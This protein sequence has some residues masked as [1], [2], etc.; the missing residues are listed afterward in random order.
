MDATFLQKL[1]GLFV[2]NPG[3]VFSII[4]AIGAAIW[5]AWWLR[6]FIGSERIATLEERLRLAGDKQTIVTSEVEKLKSQLSELTQQIE[7]KTPLQA[8]ATTTARVTGTALEL[9]NA[10]SVLGTTLSLSG[11]KYEVAGNTVDLTVTRKSDE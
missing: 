8:L 2:S 4:G 5:F 9:S 3:A 7:A 1:W 11:G 10:N 6:G